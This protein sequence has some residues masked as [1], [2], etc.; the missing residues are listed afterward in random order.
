MRYWKHSY[1]HNLFLHEAT[2]RGNTQAC[3]EVHL[4]LGTIPLMLRL[5]RTSSAFYPTDHA[6]LRFIERFA[7]NITPQEAIRRIQ[8]IARSARWERPAP[9]GADIY[10]THGYELV[11]A[12]GRIITIYGVDTRQNGYAIQA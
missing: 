1:T 11:V 2:R 3:R 7:G 8:R 10:R 5:M 4:T 12:K 9:G 6:V